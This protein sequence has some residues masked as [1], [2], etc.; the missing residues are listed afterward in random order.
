M[1]VYMALLSGCGLDELV[2]PSRVGVA[3]M[4]GCC[5]HVWVW[6]SCVGAAKCNVHVRLRAF[7]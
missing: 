3:L 5:L 1:C 7:V 2:S 4:S 6:P